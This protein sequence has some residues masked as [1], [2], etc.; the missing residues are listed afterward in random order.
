MTVVDWVIVP[1]V[2]LTVTW[3]APVGVEGTNG[4]LVLEQPAMYAAVVMRTPSNP[5]SLMA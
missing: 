1:E 4:S 2:A 5:K 3:E